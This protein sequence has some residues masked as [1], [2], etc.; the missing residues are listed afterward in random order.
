M[1]FGKR[2]EPLPE[3]QQGALGTGR[4]AERADMRLAAATAPPRQMDIEELAPAY[5]QT[6]KDPL[7]VGGPLPPSIG[8]C[9]DLYSDVRAL[10]L[11][12]EKEVAAVQAR[13]SQIREYIIA[14]LSKSAKDGDSGAAGLRYRAQIVTKEVPRAMD[15]PKIHAYIAANNR[16]DLLQ[17]RLG[18]KAVMDMAE[19]K[20]FIPG[21]EIVKVPDVSI[22]K[23]GR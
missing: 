7:E 12:M 19:D 17:K 4:G 14:N 2:V 21:I 10:R 20:Q 11:A 6:S 16:F 5:Q 23:V 1:R 22:T 15:W 8:R 9:A 18:E 3:T 13:E